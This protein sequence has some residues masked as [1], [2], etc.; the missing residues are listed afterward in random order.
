MELRSGCNVRVYVSHLIFLRR[1]R[2]PESRDDPPRPRHGRGEVEQEKQRK[3]QGAG[4]MSQEAGAA[5][6]VVWLRKE[7]IWAWNCRHGKHDQR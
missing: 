7:R 4:E 5:A 1:H 6:V 2:G 3:V